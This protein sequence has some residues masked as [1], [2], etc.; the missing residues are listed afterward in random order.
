VIIERRVLDWLLQQPGVDPNKIAYVGHSYGGIAGGVLAGIE[1]RIATFILIGA[2]PS[3]S[4]QM[5]VNRSPYWQDMRKSMSPADF[6]RTLELIH[7]IDPDHYLPAAR[8]PVLIQ[9]ARFDTDDNVRGCPEVHSLAGGLK[10]LAWYDDDHNF[11]SLE[12][13]EKNLKLNPTTLR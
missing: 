4:R 1:P 8:A 12:A 2:I 13:L 9:C 11:T 5:E 7:E 3:S 6:T 10:T